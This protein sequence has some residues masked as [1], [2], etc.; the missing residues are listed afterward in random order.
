MRLSLWGRRRPLFSSIQSHPAGVSSL[1]TVG[2][3]VAARVGT[4]L[5]MPHYEI[6]RLAPPCR[7]ALDLRSCQEGHCSSGFTV[8]AGIEASIRWG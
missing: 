4:L 5:V 2:L 7:Y 1:L 8:T 3:P 6:G